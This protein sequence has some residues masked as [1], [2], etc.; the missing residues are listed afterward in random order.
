M[1]AGLGLAQFRCF[2]VWKVDV[3]YVGLYPEHCRLRQVDI[4]CISLLQRKY[5]IDIHDV[6]VQT[7]PWKSMRVS[8]YFVGDSCS[9][10]QTIFDLALFYF[11]LYHPIVSAGRGSLPR[12]ST[13]WEQREQQ[14][15]LPKK[16]LFGYVS[17]RS[18]VHVFVTAGVMIYYTAS[19]GDLFRQE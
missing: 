1:P 4:L 18:H 9:S 11:P 3:E 14:W 12:Y 7:K 8:E 16:R 6:D 15:T 17:G 2:V 5:S 13:P 19:S 10:A